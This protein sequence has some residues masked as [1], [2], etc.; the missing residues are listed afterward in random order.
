MSVFTRTQDGIVGKSTWYKI[1]YIYVSVKK[2][3]QLGSEGEEAT[4]EPIDGA[5]GGTTLKL[6]SSGVAVEQLQYYL[7]TVSDFVTTMSAITVDGKF[8]AATEA[9]VKAYQA[10]RG[11][12]VDGLVGSTTWN[13]LYEEYNSIY[14][15]INPDIDY[16]GQYPGKSFQQGSTGNQVKTIQFWLLV[17]SANYSS[18]PKITP[19]GI[20]G[21]ATTSAVKAFQSLTGLTV[22][23]VVG[24]NTWNKL[25]EVYTDVINSLLPSNQLP[26][27]YPGS[28]LA[29]GSTGS[30]VKEMQYYLGL[31]SAYYTSIP[32]ISYDG[33]FGSETQKAVIAFQKIAGLSQ[34]GIVGP[35]TWFAIYNTYSKLRTVDGPV[36][37]Y[38]LSTY[39]PNDISESVAG[40]TSSV[41]V[42]ELQIALNSIAAFYDTIPPL[43]ITDT[44]DSATKNS[45]KAFQEEFSLPVT[46]YVDQTT[47]DAILAAYEGILSMKPR[48]INTSS[49]S[50]PGYVLTFDSA[51]VAVQQLQFYINS[52]ASRFCSGEFLREDGVYDQATSNAVTHFQ[53]D[54]G[55]PV[56]GFVDEAT[57]NVIYEYYLLD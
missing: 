12:T 17:C 56:T 40:K 50:Y 57:W 55:L 6:G 20:F 13:T 45:V 22:D 9:S 26:G 5:F 4:G 19:D 52:I 16:P 24:T 53:T 33:A 48:T 8:G 21:A 27:T 44:Y 42:K 46:G 1:S 15:D 25:Y 14:A 18:I 11:L 49:D 7:N 28:P 10:Y 51:G 54:F 2:L 3:A 36:Q 41:D 31:L 37:A 34:D 47:W 38:E 35:I 32:T 39:D 29:V 23:G 30:S 43:E